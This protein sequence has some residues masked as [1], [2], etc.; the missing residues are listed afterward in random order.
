MKYDDISS[1]KINSINLNIGF[2]D[3]LFKASNRLIDND[4]GITFGVGIEYLNNNSFGISLAS[5][6]RNS[7]YSEFKSE[8]YYKLT[9][10]FISN[11]MWF[12]KEGD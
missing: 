4:L 8:K 11:T 3:K 1:P 2:Y 9:F 10:S 12:I 7:E 6:R 5:G